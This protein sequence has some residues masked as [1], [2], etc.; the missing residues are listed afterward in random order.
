MSIKTTLNDSALWSGIWVA[1]IGAI[2]TLVKKLIKRYL[3]AKQDSHFVKDMATNHL[4]HIYHGMTEQSAA[5]IKIGAAL[6]V[7][8]KMDLDN[9]PPIRFIA[10]DKD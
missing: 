7:D 9:P 1:S 3:R 2:Y 10:E 8:I 4:P 6:G 5:L